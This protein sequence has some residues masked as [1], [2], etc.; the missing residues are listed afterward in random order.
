MPFAKRVKRLCT[1]SV[2]PESTK[3]GLMVTFALAV[4]AYLP[5]FIDTQKGNIDAKTL[6][7]LRYRITHDNWYNPDDDS[8]NV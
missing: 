4:I 5:A 1:G 6:R 2:G 8:G 7:A 3:I